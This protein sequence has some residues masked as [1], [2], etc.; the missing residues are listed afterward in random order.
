[1]R[2]LS[3][4]GTDTGRKRANNEDAFLVNDGT[5]LYAVADGIGGSEGGEVASRIAVETL[6]ESMSDLLGERD[7]T[8]AAGSTA[9]GRPE[10]PALRQAVALMNRKILDAASKNAALEGMG[11]TLTVLFVRDR[12]A[13]VAHIG[14]SR[15]YRLRSGRLGQLTHDHSMVAEQVRAGLLSAEKARMSPLRHVITRA[16]GTSGE[17]DPDVA[18]HS[19]QKGDIY[20][21]CTDG[22]T[23]MVNDREIA[24]ILAA[25]PPRDA[26]QKLIGAANERG[27]ADNITTVVVQLLEI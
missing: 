5:G 24:G 21:L 6:A 14:D 27:G 1:M 16:L 22:L 8:P 10:L 15:L 17:A 7:R 12:R 20:L 19:L 4:G 13:F 18:E 25:N 3:Y 11:T 9:D 23:D 26:V 2:I